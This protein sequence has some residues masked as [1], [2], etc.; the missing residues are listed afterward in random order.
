MRR[1][2]AGARDR[3][4]EDE[5]QDRAQAARAQAHG[6]PRWPAGIPSSRIMPTASMWPA[7]TG[8]LAGSYRPN[9]SCIIRTC[10]SSQAQDAFAAGAKRYS[11]DSPIGPA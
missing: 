2:A 5:E 3:R 7:A 4:T 10:S 9:S 6:A 1:A 8:S 11:Q